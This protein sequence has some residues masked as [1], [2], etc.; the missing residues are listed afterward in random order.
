MESNNIYLRI[1]EKSDIVATQKWI[2]SSEISEIMGYLPVL[3]YDNQIDWYDKLKNDKSRFVYAICEK[4]SGLHI[5]N[6][7]LGRIDYVNR[8]CMFNIFI[9]E[10]QKRLKGLGS[11]A[12]LL[13]LDFAFDRL[14]MHKVY[15]Q[16]S[17]RFT[18]AIKMYERLG[19]KND[20]VFREHY[21][22]KGGYEDKVIYSIIK[23]EYYGYKENK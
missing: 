22:T 8:N 10:Q 23:R 19:F 12:T 9:A 16:T 6:V 13:M 3:S 18:S 7:G 1:L 17:L 14:N 15:L 11:D 21:Y 20:G 5:G 2:N 4:E